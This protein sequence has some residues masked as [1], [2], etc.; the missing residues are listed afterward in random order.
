MELQMHY[1]GIF[2]LFNLNHCFNEISL[3]F[4]NF[5]ISFFFVFLFLI[6][7]LDNL[8]IIWKAILEDGMES[9]LD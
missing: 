7:A 4:I 3:S 8:T 6:I 9:G 5:L 1:Y 2:F